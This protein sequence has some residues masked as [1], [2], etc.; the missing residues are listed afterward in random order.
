VPEKGKSGRVSS[1]GRAAAELREQLRRGDHAPGA[2]LPSEP[3]LAAR[4]EVS[5]PTLREALRLLEDQRLIVRRHGSGTYVANRLPL[6]NSLHENFGVERLIASTGARPGV[7][8]ARWTERPADRELA[9]IL[10][11]EEGIPVSVL[12]R[13]RT[14]DD[15]PVVLSRDHLPPAAV[16]GGGPPLSG[17]LYDYLDREVG[18]PVA[19]GEADLEPDVADEAT[20]TALEA[21]VGTP[22][23]TIR[24]VDFDDAELPVLY[25]VEHHLAS[26]FQFRVH[27]AGPGQSPSR[28]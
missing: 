10:E 8:E 18:R 11:V 23:L 27:R 12:E 17:S 9:A 5:R 16:V 21:E 24:Q 6:A 4:L 3:D 13:V 15:R 26:T 2:K 25:S 20:A 22:I 7:R 1:A 19:F 28:S 14:S